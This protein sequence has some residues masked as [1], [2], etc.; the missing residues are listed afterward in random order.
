MEKPYRKEVVYI[1]IGG[2]AQMFRLGSS[3]RYSPCWTITALCK[4]RH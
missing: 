2:E 4:I 1:R 3:A